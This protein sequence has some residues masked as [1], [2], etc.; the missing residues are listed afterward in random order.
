VGK[1][2]CS[3]KGTRDT[4]WRSQET[5]TW[6]SSRDSDSLTT[7]QIAASLRHH[8]TIENGIFYV[9]DVSYGEDRSHA[10]LIGAVISAIRYLAISII[11]RAAYPYMTDAWAGI[12]CLPDLGYSLLLG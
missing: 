9:R 3:R 10:R 12:S 6:V 5:T 2:R 11:R 7:K 1:I 8:W 4:Q